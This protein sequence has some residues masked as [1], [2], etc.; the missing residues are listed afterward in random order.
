MIANANRLEQMQ[1]KALKWL[2][3]ALQAIRAIDTFTS[4]QS[5]ATFRDNELVQAGVERKFEVMAAALM[6]A[7][8]ADPAVVE[9]V[10]EL[11]RITSTR[12]RIIHDYDSVDHAIL[13][14]AILNELPSLKARLESRLEP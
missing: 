7:H 14:D 11:P 13:W 5:L 12:N 2:V 9:L 4:G 3:D 8:A 1:R 10:P 6:A